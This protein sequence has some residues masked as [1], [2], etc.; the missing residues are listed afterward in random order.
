MH[1]EIYLQWEESI[2]S[3]RRLKSGWVCLICVY[4]FVRLHTA[5]NR[6]IGE[7]SRLQSGVELKVGHCLLPVVMLSRCLHTLSQMM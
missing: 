3:G 5:P 7:S 2:D 6:P 1:R 4:R